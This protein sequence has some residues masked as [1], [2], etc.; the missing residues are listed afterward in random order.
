L[1]TPGVGQEN[2]CLATKERSSLNT[3]FISS[4]VENEKINEKVDLNKCVIFENDDISF[5]DDVES[6]EDDSVS[7]L[8]MNVLEIHNDKSLLNEC[9]IYEDDKE[10]VP[11]DDSDYESICE[12]EMNILEAYEDNTKLE[13]S[14]IKSMFTRTD[15]NVR[16]INEDDSMESF[17]N[18][19]Y[20][21]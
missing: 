7:E 10:R 8:E 9:V 19:F 13:A 2:N 5:T 14:Q 21:E 20:R 11:E 16:L 18:T 12:L 15:L 4:C 3:G 6:D 1:R 17:M